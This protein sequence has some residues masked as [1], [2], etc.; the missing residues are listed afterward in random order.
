MDLIFL[1]GLVLAGVLSFWAG[2]LLGLSKRPV[3][4]LI[5]LDRLQSENLRRRV[6]RRMIRGQNAG[7]SDI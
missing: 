1:G 4:R 3:G 5:S 7:E 2:Y 6:E